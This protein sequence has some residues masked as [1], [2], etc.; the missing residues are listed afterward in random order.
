MLNFFCYPLCQRVR[1]RYRQTLADCDRTISAVSL[2]ANQVIVKRERKRGQYRDIGLEQEFQDQVQLNRSSS[3]QLLV[4]FWNW[5]A[6]LH[7][8]DCIQF[9]LLQSSLIREYSVVSL[10]RRRRVSIVIPISGLSRSSLV[11]SIRF[12]VPC[13]NDVSK[14]LPRLTRLLYVPMLIFSSLTPSSLGSTLGYLFYLTFCIQNSD[15]WV[16]N[17]TLFIQFVHYFP[18]PSASDSKTF[19]ILK[20]IYFYLFFFPLIGFAVKG[21]FKF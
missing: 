1:R 19:I 11:C 17:L 16:E 21:I 3:G 20:V 13:P 7:A 6:V 4:L 8:M 9:N 5:R 14:G 10:E 15:A 12:N 2:P 18:M